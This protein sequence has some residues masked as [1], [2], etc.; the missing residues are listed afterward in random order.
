MANYM[1]Q[2]DKACTKSLPTCYVHVLKSSRWRFRTNIEDDTLCLIDR[3]AFA[4]LYLNDDDLLMFVRSTCD[5]MVQRGQL[6]AI[7]LTGLCSSDFITLI[8]NYVD[9]T[10]DVQSAAIV[11]LHACHLFSNDCYTVIN[12]DKRT[13]INGDCMQNPRRSQTGLNCMRSTNMEKRLSTPF[14]GVSGV[15]CTSLSIEE[16][17]EIIKIGGPKLANWVQCYRDLLDQWQMWFCRA[18]FDITYKSRI[19]SDYMSSTSNSRNQMSSSL[20]MS[21]KTIESDM[22]TT[23]AVTTTSTMNTTN[24]A[25][26]C[27]VRNIGLVAGANQVFVA[28]GFCGWRLEPQSYKLNMSSITCTVNSCTSGTGNNPVTNSISTSGGGGSSNSSITNSSI[29]DNPTCSSTTSG[30]QMHGGGGKQTIC[31]RCRK[32]LPRC[33]ICLMHLGTSIPL[34]EHMTMSTAARGESML[35]QIALSS[36]PELSVD[37]IKALQVSITGATVSL[38]EGPVSK[39]NP[40]NIHSSSRKSSLLANSSAIADWFVWC[41]ACRHGGHASHLIDWFYGDSLSNSNDIGH[42]KE[43]PVSGCQCRCAALDT[44]QNLLPLNYKRL[45]INSNAE[46][47]DSGSVD[48]EPIGLDDIVLLQHIF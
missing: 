23:T 20:L 11:G 36:A 18:D 33:S 4:C 2:L 38:P 28:C 47:E 24:V 45:S 30:L 32:P 34:N 13:D 35:R 40:K 21:S 25:H 26:S 48:G 16:R 43:C 42:F 5:S 17:P 8:Q 31:Q 15:G 7:L 41:Q 6:E 10:G 27:K 9:I 1:C 22:A 12:N 3:V 29:T 44:N 39:G 14:G 19:L 46:S 37:F